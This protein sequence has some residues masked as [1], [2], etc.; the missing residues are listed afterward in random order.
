MAP[1]SPANREPAYPDKKAAARLSATEGEIGICENH[2]FKVYKVKS[3]G[4]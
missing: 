2:M 4:Y 3:A 1:S